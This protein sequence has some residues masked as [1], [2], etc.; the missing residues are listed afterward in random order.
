MACSLCAWLTMRV[1]VTQTCLTPC[2]SM[3]Q[4][5][6]SY[7]HGILQARIL[8]VGSHSLLQEIFLTQGWNLGPLHCRQ[9]LYHVSHQEVL[10][11]I[12]L[13]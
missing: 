10:G 3:D 9:I 8:G 13:C 5:P 1:L 2:N 4:N 11:Q 6:K 7:I 12:P